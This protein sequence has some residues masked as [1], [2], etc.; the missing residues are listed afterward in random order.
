MQPRRSG[1]SI[2]GDIFASWK[3][4]RFIHADRDLFPEFKAR[5]LIVL[6]DVEY[7]VEQFD[8]L[9][10]WCGENNCSMTG[11]TVELPTDETLMLFKLRW[12]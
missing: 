11:M 9:Y 3:Q 4:Q 8:E 5:H 12:S 7:W 1:K 2:M 6:T 10:S